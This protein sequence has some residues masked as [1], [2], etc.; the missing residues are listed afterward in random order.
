MGPLC[1]GAKFE[2]R[3]R[4][5]NKDQIKS[6]EQKVTSLTSDDVCGATLYSPL[7][8]SGGHASKILM[9]LII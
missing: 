8:D 3:A 4:A 9:R 1:K 7:Y 2:E 6:G 5:G